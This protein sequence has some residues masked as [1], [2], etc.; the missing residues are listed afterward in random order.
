MNSQ[1][2]QHSML[3]S[4]LD[5]KA[6]FF[7]FFF[8]V[9][10]KNKFYFGLSQMMQQQ[11]FNRTTTTTTITK[12]ALIFIASFLLCATSAALA[13]STPSRPQY[14]VAFSM[15]YI[16]VASNSN[17]TS[18]VLSQGMMW[19]SPQSK[20]RMKW[21]KTTTKIQLKRFFRK[22]QTINTNRE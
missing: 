13:A 8:F 2:Q 10:S 6:F 4:K 14:D 18:N 16:E 5:G 20:V 11:Q 19:V 15:K 17:D 12:K 21:K 7:F 3:R 1:Q 9:L 22:T